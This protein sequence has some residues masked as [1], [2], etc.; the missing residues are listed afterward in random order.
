MTAIASSLAFVLLLGNDPALDLNYRAVQSWPTALACSA[1]G[2]VFIMAI[3]QIIAN[4]KGHV[5]L[6]LTWLGQNTLIILVFH[7]P[8]QNA[9][10]NLLSKRIAINAI[11]ATLI[12]VVLCAALAWLSHAVINRNKH[13]R[14]IFYA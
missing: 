7:A 1:L 6:A 9:L 8:I 13:L 10:T 12:S 14:S 11:L 5:K 3:S 2:I 4:S